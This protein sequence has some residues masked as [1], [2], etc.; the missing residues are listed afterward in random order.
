MQSASRTA[1]MAG[2]QSPRNRM[3][4]SAAD[5]Q[6]AASHAAAASVPTS[7]TTTGI[8]MF[9]RSLLLHRAGEL[10]GIGDDLVARLQTAQDLLRAIPARGA[11]VDFHAAEGLAAHRTEDPIL[12]VQPQNGGGGHEHP[13]LGVLGDE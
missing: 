5:A 12:I 10:E 13:G 4:R 9:P 7:K 6:R 1:S 2:G 8:K 3:G 11:G